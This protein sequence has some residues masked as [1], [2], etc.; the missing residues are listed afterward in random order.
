MKSIVSLPTE[1]ELRDQWPESRRYVL[2]ARKLGYGRWIGGVLLVVGLAIC[3][4]F[5]F[6]V[7]A[8]VVGWRQFAN[9]CTMFIAFILG[10]ATWGGFAPL[11]WGLNCLLGHRELVIRDGYL[12]TVERVGPWWRS[13]RWK[14]ESIRSLEI[15]RISPTKPPPIDLLGEFNALVLHTREGKQG[16]LA[17]G[18]P[19][20]MLNAFALVL[21]QRL[22][23]LGE[24]LHRQSGQETE[25]ERIQ[26]RLNKDE[27]K[28][29]KEEAI[30]RGQLPVAKAPSRDSMADDE[31]ADEDADTDERAESYADLPPVKPS[32]SLIEIDELGERE[33][34][35][36]IP[37]LG[38]WKGS[39]GLF[40]FSL[41]WCGFMVVFDGVALS[42]MLPNIFQHKDAWVFIGF[43]ALFWL[44]GLGMLLAAINM[45][46]RKA[47]LAVVGGQL[48][49]IQ[50]GL[51]GS[52]KREWLCSEVETIALG[53]SGMEVNDVP[54]LQL[55]IAS[56]DN[57]VFG[58]LT[59][60]SEDELEWLAWMLRRAVFPTSDET[61]EN[62]EHSDETAP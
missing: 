39:A 27:E 5:L 15:K 26:V 56:N 13:R 11:W 43:S 31:L 46:R 62:G 14:I 12:R 2:P 18:Y 10:P 40:V 4:S 7:Y 41:I 47:A 42:S 48:M 60:R 61:S 35:I 9:P 53:P 22:H 51:F 54:V 25:F 36:R 52:K 55:Q 58:M 45:G 38:I 32:D 20:A 50:T 6:M 49:A 19:V 33:I 16:M 21:A 8:M 3:V 28:W 1:I 37:P 59:G 30:K 23:E 24:D 44:V 57:V 17:W 29:A 34:T